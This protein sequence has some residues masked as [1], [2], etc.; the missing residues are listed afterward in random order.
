MDEKMIGC[1]RVD[2]FLKGSSPEVKFLGQLQ[3]LGQE[4]WPPKNFN[5]IKIVYCHFIFSSIPSLASITMSW[6]KILD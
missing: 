5:M 4:T 6:A 2:T 1:Q 3:N